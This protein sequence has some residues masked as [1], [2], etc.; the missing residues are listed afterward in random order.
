MRL[1]GVYLFGQQCLMVVNGAVRLDKM[2]TFRGFV[3]IC[4]DK[5]H[6][7]CGGL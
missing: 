2:H 1:A 3:W 6:Y 5:F 7:I 4:L